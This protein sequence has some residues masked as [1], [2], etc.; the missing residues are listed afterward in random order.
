METRHAAAALEVDP[1]AAYYSPI[2][3]SEDYKLA[4]ATFNHS[5]ENDPLLHNSSIIM[6]QHP[7][8]APDGFLRIKADSKRIR[9]EMRSG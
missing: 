3:G 4:V 2:P 6:Y 9:N 1:M 8:I 7:K 5:P